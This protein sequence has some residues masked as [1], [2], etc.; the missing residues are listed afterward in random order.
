MTTSANTRCDFRTGVVIIGAGQAGLSCSHYLAV[1]G[2]EHVVLER[3]EVANSWRTERWDSLRL[4]TPNWQSQLP[5]WDYDGADPDGFMDMA[6]VIEFI[7][8]YARHE[9]APV[10]VQ[11]TVTGVSALD[12]GY[13]VQTD[14]GSWHCR[15]VVVASGAFN[16]P[17]VPALAKALP[18]GLE[19]LT[20][21]QYRN[22][23][24]LRE[25]GVLVV[26]A[27]ATGLQIADEI[28]RSGREVTLAVGEHVRMPRTYRGRDIQYWLQVCGLLDEPYWQVDELARVRRLP[29]PQLIGTPEKRNLDLNALDDAGVNVVG[30]LAGY[31]G[32]NAQFSGSLGNVIRLADLKLGR[33]LD[34][35]DQWID[36]AGQD[37]PAEPP[38]R[39]EPT[40][41]PP[42]PQLA[43]DLT[44]GAVQTV[45]WATGYRPD[46]SWLNLPVLDR[47]GQA[48]HDGGVGGLPGIYFM[49]LPFMRR[50]NSSFIAGTGGDARDICRHLLGY[51]RP[52]VPWRK[53]S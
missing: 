36:G 51:L 22:P 18:D 30:R 14:R 16:T 37:S 15:C 6:Q 25:G 20:T 41:L 40:R 34:S 13:R 27:A 12:R 4:L 50:R 42:S 10:R 26:G 29:S 53:V 24:Q 46:Y 39:P 11:T 32:R 28:R 5:G 49:G 7:A 45:L 43:L 2:I 23:A 35:I 52:A 47:R 38:W 1:E 21:H 9:A 33:L 17:L 31:D 3:G 48:I 8:G 19:Q 44:A